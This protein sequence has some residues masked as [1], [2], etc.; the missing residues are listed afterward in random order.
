MKEDHEV[1]LLFQFEDKIPMCALVW[2]KNHLK[3]WL[4]SLWAKIKCTHVKKILEVD[5]LIKFDLDMKE[6]HEEKLLFQFEDKIPMCAL[7]WV[8]NHLNLWL[9]SLWTKIKCTHVKNILEVGVLKK[10]D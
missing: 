6:D 7:V 8:K 5:V 4:T 10:F 2:V 3:L 1:K 9:T